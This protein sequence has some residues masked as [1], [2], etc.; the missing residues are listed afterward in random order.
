MQRPL[1][2]TLARMIRKRVVLK[3]DPEIRLPEEEARRIIMELVPE[4]AGIT[5]IMFDK[6]MGEV[7]IEAKKPGLVIGKSGSLLR[8]I[9]MK[10][11]WRPV[12]IRTPPLQSH[13]AT[14]VARF[15]YKNS[16]YRQKVL[17]NIGLRIHRSMP[18]RKGRVK[19]TALGGFLEVGRSAI[20][21]E[22]DESKILLDCGVK[23]GVAGRRRC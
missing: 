23:P 21:V 6:T 18:I 4:D 15:I 9:L 5:S 22:A 3:T 12:V 10:T 14:Q 2:K 13:I 20:L 11:L 1:M 8:T 17:K 19:I 16:G 7:L